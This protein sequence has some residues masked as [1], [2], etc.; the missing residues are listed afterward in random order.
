MSAQHDHRGL[1]ED[2]REIYREDVRRAE[3]DLSDR[4]SFEVRRNPRSSWGYGLSVLAAA[5]LLVAGVAALSRPPTLLT[6]AGTPA[7][8]LATGNLR[9]EQTLSPGPTSP[10]RTTLVDGLPTE[11]GGVTVLRGEAALSAVE[12]ADSDQPLLVGGWHFGGDIFCA[13]LRSW[14]MSCYHV[15]LQESAAS[16]PSVSLY[17]GPKSPDAPRLGEEQTQ[18]IVVQVHTHD[19]SCPPAVAICATRP[20]IDAVIWSGMVQA[21]PR[22]YG[23]APSGGLSQSDAVAAARNEA[24]RRS[25]SP[26]TFVS[27]QAGPYGLVGPAG[28][29]VAADHWIWAIVFSGD[30][31]APACSGTACHSV[32]TDLVVIDYIGGK[33]LIEEMPA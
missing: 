28:D 2:L 31:P 25:R 6:E 23:S 17:L 27:A 9:A 4:G 32:D 33:V 16:G 10:T 15:R 19:A 21:I 14:W 18:P 7:S 30:F 8:Q 1:V 3:R 24:E 26:V 12:S 5:V 22:K 29:D 20:V 11:L 13:A